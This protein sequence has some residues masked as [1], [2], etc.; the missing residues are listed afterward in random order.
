[1]NVVEARR[2]LEYAIRESGVDAHGELEYL[3]SVIQSGV[4]AYD[5][6][7]KVRGMC[8]VWA[9]REPQCAGVRAIRDELGEI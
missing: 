5:A 9:E 2:V 3:I 7:Q 8:D 6:L 1:M 4:T